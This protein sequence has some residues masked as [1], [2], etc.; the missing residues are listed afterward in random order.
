MP[1][2][3]PDD[4]NTLRE[5]LERLLELQVRERRQTADD[6]LA[7]QERLRALSE[8][9][10]ERGEEIERLTNRLLETEED[11]E[12]LTHLLNKASGGPKRAQLG[13]TPFERFVNAWLRGG[14]SAAREP[15]TPPGRF[16]FHL[17][18]SPYRIRRH[19]KARLRGWI[20][21][22]EALPIDAV[23]VRYA[24]KEFAAKSGRTEGA[25]FWFE[26]EFLT[27][28]G[29]HWLRLEARAGDSDWQTALKIPSW[30]IRPES[31]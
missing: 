10:G 30:C 6:L 11:L 7:L 28:P 29:I 21:S 14:A 5:R 9:V 12:T 2:P 25:E 24:G 18:E 19:A 31:D 8:V 26:V 1:D 27:P 16:Q 13:R 15:D 22:E 20:V 4:P 3:D 17:D 23:R